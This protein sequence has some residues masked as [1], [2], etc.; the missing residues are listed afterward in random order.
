MSDIIIAIRVMCNREIQGTG[1]ILRYYSPLCPS[2]ASS[3]ANLIRSGKYPT[4]FALLSFDF[5]ATM[6]KATKCLIQR[7]QREYKE[8][9]G[10]SNR[11]L[12]LEIRAKP[13]EPEQGS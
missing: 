8:D 10:E 2:V 1:H 6:I 7:A 9:S 5:K 4:G 3:I 13:Y 12:K 11:K